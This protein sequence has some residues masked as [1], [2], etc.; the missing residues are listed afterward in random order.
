MR[1]VRAQ[2]FSVLK[3]WHQNV[4]AL[5]VRGQNF[6]VQNFRV[7]TFRMQKVSMRMF[8]AQ[9]FRVLNVRVRIFRV[10]IFRVQTFWAQM[11]RARN[12]STLNVRGRNFR[13]R[14]FRI[15]RAGGPTPITVRPIL[16]QI[17]KNFRQKKFSLKIYS[18]REF[19]SIPNLPFTYSK[20]SLQMFTR[21][22]Q[23][24]C[25]NRTFVLLTRYVIIL[26]IFFYL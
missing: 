23:W 26:Y 8:R 16:L 17:L 13:P 14:T 5:N 11:F 20:K 9:T 12:V 3:F 15:R 7:L 19:I 1:N 10:L 25:Q 22:C 4:S 18:H 2:T 21:N 6:C 24:F